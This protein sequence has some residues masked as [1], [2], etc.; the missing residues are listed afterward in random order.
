MDIKT[1]YRKVAG[2]IVGKDEPR[3][4]GV[5]SLIPDSNLHILDLG[6][7]DGKLSSL[8]KKTSNYVVGADIHADV[9][10][11]AKS[12][13]NE[14][15]VIDLDECWEDLKDNSFDIVVMSA[16]LE[17]VFDYRNIFAEVRRVL[18]PK[19]FFIHATPNA[20][21]LKSRLQL[22]NGDVPDWFKNFEH[23]RQWTP[24][25][26]RNMLKPYNFEEVCLK[27]CYVRNSKVSSIHAK[28]FPNLAPIFIQK[29][30][31]SD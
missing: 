27:G 23:I 11:H 31:L 16:V 30:K 6:C 28:I 25:Y 20:A 3:I 5:V 18:R 7:Y 21:S 1:H 14:T 2:G 9:L 10:K 12:N 19:G 4:S 13:I 24:M 29:F 17:H 22:L 26:L 15:Y 8:Y